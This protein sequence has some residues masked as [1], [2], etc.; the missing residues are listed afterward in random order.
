M[1][2]RNE[3]AQPLGLG[4]RDL[5]SEG[6]QPVGGAALVAA[7]RRLANHALGEQALDDAVERASAQHDRAGGPLLDLLEDRVAMLLAVGQRQQH[8]EERRGQRQQLGR[9][10][11]GHGATRYVVSRRSVK[12]SGRAASPVSCDSTAG[13]VFLRRRHPSYQHDEREAEP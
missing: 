13:S 3:I 12:T 9:I 7:R 1:P 11:V 2:T 5:A 10:A 4:E 6:G 8:V